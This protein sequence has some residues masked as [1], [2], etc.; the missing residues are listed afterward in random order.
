MR[1]LFSD[2]G[3]WIAVVLGLPGHTRREGK[4]LTEEFEREHRSSAASS[5]EE[6]QKA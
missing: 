3:R 6:R 2:L 4:K 5:A 1:R